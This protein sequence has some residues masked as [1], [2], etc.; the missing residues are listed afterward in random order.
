MT[1]TRPTIY[2]MALGACL[3]WLPIESWS[4]PQSSAPPILLLGVTPQGTDLE[5]PAQILFQ[6][7]TP[8]VPLGRMERRSDQISIKISPPLPCE[9]RW[10]NTSTLGCTL[11]EAHR[12][13]PS[14][15]YSI[16]VPKAF[17]VKRGE[18]LSESTTISFTTKRPQISESWF[19]GWNGPGT[20]TIAVSVNQRVDP[21]SLQER[22]AFQDSS[23]RRYP[24]TVT[25]FRSEDEG[26]E[27]DEEEA[28]GSPEIDGLRW[29]VSPREELP[30]ETSLNLVISPGLEPEEGSQTGIEDRTITSFQTF[31]AFSF[32]GII[33]YDLRGNPVDLSFPL[34]PEPTTLVKKLCDPLNS[35][36]LAFNAPVKSDQLKTALKITPTLSSGGED[37]DL[38]MEVGS[39]SQLASPNY[40]GKKFTISLPHGLKADSLY[41]LRA[42]AGTLRDEFGR[43]LPNDIDASFRTAHRAPRYVLDNDISIIEKNADSKLPIIVNNLSSLTLSY[44]AVTATR[45]EKGLSKVL[46]PYPARDIAYRFPIDIREILKGQ[47]GLIQG[48]L[49]TNP[50]TRSGSAWFLSEVTPYDVHLK[51]G[52]FS[53][54]VWVTSF[55]TGEPVSDAKVSIGIDTLTNWSKDRRVLTTAR[56]TAHGLATLAGTN[57]IDP[58]LTLSD[59]WQTK[60][61][62][63]VVTVEKDGDVAIL[64]LTWSFQAYSGADYPVARPRHGHIHTWGTTAQGV[65]KAGDTVQFAVWVRDQNDTAFI[66][67]PR[68]T[69]TLEVSDPTG[70]AIYTEPNITLSQFGSHAGHF[71]TKTDSAVGWYT[72]ALTSSFSTERWEPLRVLIS[73]FTP[74]PFQV[75]SEIHGNYFGEGDSLEVTTTARLHAGGPYSD[76]A[77]RTTALVRPLTPAAKEPRFETFSFDS[78]DVKEQQIYQKEE[79]LDSQ[80]NHSATISI[81]PL[82][83]PYGEITVES[84]VRDDRGKFISAASRAPFIGRAK[85]VG[86]TQPDWILTA[87]KETVIQGVIIDQAGQASANVPFTVSIE[88]EETKA[89]RIKSAGNSY[90]TKYDHDWRLV[91]ECRLTSSTEPSPCSFTPEKAGEYRITGRVLDEKNREHSTALR[92]LSAGKDVVL[93]DNG[94]NNSLEIIP[95]KKTYQVGEVARFLIQN[96]FPGAKALLTTERY[97]IQRSWVITLA[98][99]SH[100]IEVPVT[101]DHIPGFF[102]S[103]TVMSPRVA[104]PVENGVDLGKPTFRM[105]YSKIDVL[106]PAKQ[107]SVEVKPQAELYRPRETVTVDITAPNHRHREHP[108]EYAVTVLDEAVF[109][110]I[111]GGDDYFNPYKGF[112]TLDG[113]DVKN[114]NLIKMLVGRQLFEKKGANVGGDGGQGLDVRSVNKYVTYWNPALKPDENGKAT[115]TFEAPDN[116]TK[117]RVVVIAMTDRDQMGMGVGSF[118]VNKTTEL[119]AALP[120]QVKEGDTFVATFTV[121]NR[122]ERTR[123]LTIQTRSEGGI[124]SPPQS[125][126]VNAEPFKRYPIAIKSEASHPGTGRFIIS[127]G[128]SSDTDEVVESVSILPRAS[129]Q[130]AATFGSSDASEATEEINFPNNLKPGIGS[131][132]VVLSSSLLGGLDGAFSYLRDYPYSCWEQK[133]SKGV[134]AAHYVAL[135]S[136]LPKGFEWDGATGVVGRTLEEMPSNQANNGGMAF[137]EASNDRVDPFLSAY[138]AIALTWLRERGYTIPKEPE[139]KLIA[140]LK[141]ILRN[142]SFPSYFSP[143]M[144]SNVRS[145]ALAA[146]AARGSL[147]LSDLLRYKPKVAEMNLFGKANILL[148]ATDLSDTSKLQRELVDQIL[149]QSNE[150]GATLVFT[151]P[152]EA[153][154]ARFLDSSM[155]SQCAILSAFVAAASHDSVLSDR[156]T[157]LIPKIVRSITLERKRKDRWENTQENLFCVNALTSYSKRFESEARTIDLE[158]RLGDEELSKI[159]IR[160][161]SSEPVEVTRPL[162]SGDAGRSD[163]LIISPRGGGK[164]YY[165]TRLTYSPAEL[166]R[167]PVNSGI[168]IAREYSVQRNGEWTLL[169]DPVKIRQGELIKVDLFIQLAAPRNFVVVDDPVPGG[170]EPVNRDLASSSEVDAAKGAYVGAQGS[171]WFDGRQ[172]I[173]FGAT[174]QSFYHKELR[175][176]SA[177][178]YSE[179]LPA[180]NYHLSYVSQAIAIGEFIILPAHVEEMYDPDVF[181]NTAPDLLRVESAQ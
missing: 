33:C 68:A 141:A 22:L 93:W 90:V 72:F 131:I 148:A 5:P 143:G 20:P 92:R 85:Y 160:G 133:L 67:A 162:R 123:A 130:T 99:S 109:D 8:V 34:P 168:E 25:K 94:S 170:L 13:K 167:S 46:T 76:A 88:Y 126:T 117:W 152:L 128:D 35:I 110:L 57:T 122:G 41:T 26:G 149:S 111:R 84:S 82:S 29:L 107:I 156:L 45:N 81:P 75:A 87:G 56:T 7:N 17:D 54:L 104:K 53:S 47:S 114:F 179:Y 70:K 105:G 80:G 77:I 96:P 127:A 175:H 173:D 4:E 78:L 40:K 136:Y 132:G 63:L 178:F 172:W 145:L 69:Y 158:V 139:D 106:D 134:M 59:E 120:N 79:T 60:K 124:T 31:P 61:P 44:Q 95:E 177:R 119:R 21:A 154:S 89:A 153:I 38:W 121:M 23:G 98:Q 164:F 62:R 28:Q 42:A 55:E 3:S 142:E 9:W 115:V 166:P 24:V 144:K 118:Q 138:T 58:K 116:L 155:R 171:Q 15:T 125:M 112:Y 159:S 100:V 165:S 50:V 163:S 86:L 91:H 6:F 146:L 27:P 66:P 169:R 74:A 43:S 181:G 48:T 14:T 151:E 83:V 11:A 51:L 19:R 147:T 102:F 37:A 49:S 174:F 103:A 71:T 12:P 2:L 16:H 180:G 108:V 150:R 52:H 65:Y 64:P 10:V 157:P 137:Y 73:D 1:L 18:V 129:L 32:L 140:Y 97:G 113:L 135:R 36:S 161:K 30:L 39:Y 101:R 176:A